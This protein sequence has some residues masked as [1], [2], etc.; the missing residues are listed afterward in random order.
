VGKDEVLELVLNP[1]PN[2]IYETGLYRLQLADYAVHLKE[3]Q[4][5]EWFV[6]VVRDPDQRSSDFMASGLIRYQPKTAITLG[7][8]GDNKTYTHKNLF[9]YNAVAE[10]G[11]QL[12]KNPSN[13]QH[14]QAFSNSNIRLSSF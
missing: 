2:Q 4:K 7:N 1:A 8:Q 11:W 14:R 13:Q 6:T 10:I 3:N 5:Y 9:W 12:E